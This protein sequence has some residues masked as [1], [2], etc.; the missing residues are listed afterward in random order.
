MRGCAIALLA[1]HVVL[2]HAAGQEW[3]VDEFKNEDGSPFRDID[4]PTVIRQGPD[5]RFYVGAKGTVSALTVDD[6]YRVS[7]VCTSK[8]FG[9]DRTVLGL[10][11]D[12]RY[13][14]QDD[15]FLYIATSKLNWAGGQH[16]DAEQFPG[17]WAN[18]M[19]QIMRSNQGGHC[20]AVTKN[21]VTGLSVSNHDHG[22]NGMVIDL[23]G[24]L[25][26]LNGGMTNAGFSE[27]GD[28]DG[29]APETPLSG[30]LLSVRLNIDGFNGEVEYDTT[31]GRQADISNE[32]DVEVFA[33][34][35]MNAF[36]VELHT[37]GGLYVTDNGPNPGYG[38]ESVSCSVNL[39][40]EPHEDDTLHLAEKGKWYGHP[41]RNRGRYDEK[42]CV[43]QGE[44]RTEAVTH[45]ESSTNGLTEYSSNKRGAEWKG[46]LVL[47][48]IGFHGGNNDRGNSFALFLSDQRTVKRREEVAN[49]G[50][51]DATMDMNG[52]LVL[53]DYMVRAIVVLRSDE[54]TTVA[55]QRAAVWSVL[56]RR[57]PARGGNRVWVRGRFAARALTVMFGSRVCRDVRVVREGLLNCRAPAGVRGESIVVSVG[58]GRWF[59]RSFGG[60][61]YTYMTEQ[62]GALH[63]HLLETT[64][65]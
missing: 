22:V 61:D 32:P 16:G 37:N 24:T 54:A 6:D 35:F 42:Q 12:P 18:G 15:I 13:F 50:G 39:E 36:S 31:D 11:F 7:D 56:P 58:V 41:N 20:L 57:G 44:G 53:T 4:A 3:V 28:G 59:S 1:L 17:G 27:K 26:V 19:V 29:G 14:R 33:A 38:K 23:D 62:R 64:A 8:N 21:V 65:L 52:N 5:L 25:K 34:G 48:R 51:L 49:V 30:A 43:Y 2:R 9:E 10:T 55:R 40:S 60:A 45:M 46:A 63:A 47:A